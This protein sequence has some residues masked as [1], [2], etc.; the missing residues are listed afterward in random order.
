MGSAD[1]VDQVLNLLDGLGSRV[2]QDGVAAYRKR[3]KQTHTHTQSRHN[4]NSFQCYL[5]VD[6]CRLRENEWV[7]CTTSTVCDVQ[8]HHPFHTPVH[9]SL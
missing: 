3:A 4:V 1:G 6:F 2:R 7:P 9:S 8:Q 5:A